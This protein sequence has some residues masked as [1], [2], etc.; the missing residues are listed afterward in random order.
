M[1][2]SSPL[3]FYDISSPREPRS[4]APNPSKARLALGFKRASFK[5]TWVDIIGIP[6]V[7]KGLNCPATRKFDNGSD[8]YTLPMLRDPAS[9]RVVG[10]SFDIANYLEDTFPDS[11]G[12]LFPSDSTR[13]GLDYESPNKD[14]AFFA[15]LTSN[16]GSKNEAYARF[17]QNV[18]ATFSAFIVL[19]AQYLP[20]N[21]STADAAKALFVQRAHL[22]SWDSICLQGEAR[23]PIRAAFKVALTSLAQLFMVHEIGPY[24]EGKEANYADMIVGGWLNMMSATMPEEEWKDFRTWH[25]GVFGRL[26]DALQENYLELK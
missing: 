5:T 10:D 7:R 17:N 2:D 12:R 1:T 16:K 22:S 8:F 25:G 13:T 11:G 14:T 26:H 20:F 19:V 24:L 18:D 3:I 4:Y 9:G 23:E 15:P 21:P 6:D